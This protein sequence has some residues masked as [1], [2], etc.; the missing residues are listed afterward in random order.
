MKLM[1]DIQ[2]EIHSLEAWFRENA[3]IPCYKSW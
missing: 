3:A 1:A 2:I